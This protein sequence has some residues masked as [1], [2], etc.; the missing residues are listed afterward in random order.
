MPTV[1][2]Q[3]GFQVRIYSHD[4]FPPHVHVLRGAGLIVVYLNGE[5]G[6]EEG[7]LWVREC[8]GLNGREER[9]ALALVESHYEFL[10][11]KWEEIHG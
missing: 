8:H 2:R 3:N 1:L 4:H 10:R 9:Q 5:E 6:H 11:V 7:R